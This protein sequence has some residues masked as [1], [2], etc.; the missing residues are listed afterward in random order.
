MATAESPDDAR[1]SSTA[2]TSRSPQSRIQR[3]LHLHHSLSIGQ[4]VDLL[5]PISELQNLAQTSAYSLCTCRR[6][7]EPLSNCLCRTEDTAAPCLH[8][9]STCLRRPQRLRLLSPLSLLLNI[10]HIAPIVN[11]PVARYH[12]RSELWLRCRAVW[13]GLGK[14]TK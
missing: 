6:S 2:L 4:A 13:G 11:L 3:F 5:L 12:R 14:K 10:H 1:M 8:Q 9:R 7:Y